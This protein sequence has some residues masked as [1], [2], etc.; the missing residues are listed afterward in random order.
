MA[1]NPSVP[2]KSVPPLLNELVERFARNAR[3]YREPGYKEMQLRQEF[4]NPLFG[5][6][7]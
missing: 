5:L 6:L 7:G 1:K 3:E 2:L 4:L